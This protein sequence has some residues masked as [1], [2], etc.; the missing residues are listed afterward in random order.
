MTQ[1]QQDT[2]GSGLSLKLSTYTCPKHGT[3]DSIV[4]V[5]GMRSDLD[6]DYCNM[7][8]VEWIVS[9]LPRVTKNVTTD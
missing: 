1:D 5:Y 7:C 8:Y 4:K 9:I 3:I 6:G 2:V